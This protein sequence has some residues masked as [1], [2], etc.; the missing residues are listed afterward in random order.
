MMRTWNCA[1][2]AGFLVCAMSGAA[3]AQPK[4]AEPQSSNMGPP[5]GN[6]DGA[7]NGIGTS[8]SLTGNNG[9]ASSTVNSGNSSAAPAAVGGGSS[10]GAG[11][12]IENDPALGGGAQK[13]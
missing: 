3:L 8:G 7:S 12:P 2:A 5:S 11:G 10:S 13:K 9:S 6:R 1:V 4:P